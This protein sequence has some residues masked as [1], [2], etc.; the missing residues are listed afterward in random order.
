M[1]AAPRGRRRRGRDRRS[2]VPE[3]R[4]PVRACEEHGPDGTELTGCAKVYVPIDAAPSA[5]RYGFVFA[6]R[7]GLESGDLVLPLIAF[8]ER[9]PSVGRNVYE[10]A[11]RRL[12]GRYT[13]QG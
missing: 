5:A 12:H 8:G 1:S 9:H 11:H 10:R 13:D 3:R 6:L 7:A 4:L 2:T